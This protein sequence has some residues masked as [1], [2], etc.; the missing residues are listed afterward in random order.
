MNAN[1]TPFV[2]PKLHKYCPFDYSP[3]VVVVP[4]ALLLKQFHVYISKKTVA[5]SGNDQAE[6]ELSKLVSNAFHYQT[7]RSILAKLAK[8]T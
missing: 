1:E 4:V 5:G 6:R 7:K 3:H 2:Y 8:L